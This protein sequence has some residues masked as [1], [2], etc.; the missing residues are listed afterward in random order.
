M[1]FLHF[2][3]YQP[4]SIIRIYAV[5]FVSV[6]PL[7]SDRCLTSHFPTFFQRSLFV[8]L[9]LVYP[10]KF[11][12]SCF[13]DFVCRQLN[14]CDVIYVDLI[15]FIL[16]FRK[17]T[18][19]VFFRAIRLLIGNCTDIEVSKIFDLTVDFHLF[20]NSF[21]NC[22]YQSGWIYLRCFCTAVDE[23]YV[24]MPSST[25]CSLIGTVALQD[26]CELPRIGCPLR[27]L[28]YI[29]NPTRVLALHPPST[30]GSF[31][32]VDVLLACESNHFRFSPWRRM[33]WMFMKEV[34]PF[35]S[36]IVVILDRYLQLVSSFFQSLL[37]HFFRDF[38]LVQTL[39]QWER[40]T[41]WWSC[42]QVRIFIIQDRFQILLVC[43][44]R[45]IPS[46]TVASACFQVNC[47]TWF[48]SKTV[49][50][51]RETWRWKYLRNIVLSQCMNVQAFTK[52]AKHFCIDGFFLCID[53]SYKMYIDLFDCCILWN[54]WC[55]LL[56]I[57]RF[58]RIISNISNLFIRQFRTKMCPR[59]SQTC[60]SG[61]SSR[62]SWCFRF[63]QLMIQI[64]QIF[65]KSLST[66]CLCLRFLLRSRRYNFIRISS[67][68][69]WFS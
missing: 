34:S 61:R 68:S 65:S 51:L 66:L 58:H 9:L 15:F 55:H 56:L 46:F 60:T 49:G 54:L 63:F 31:D 64:V 13:Q 30:H 23:L 62:N 41:G 33:G 22:C 2:P 18:F 3:N 69:Q 24:S 20:S 27:R 43:L 8:D 36:S 25:V 7:Q 57:W 4:W 44:V 10:T 53:K 47:I 50:S 21:Q 59:H 28:S 1:L 19:K 32:H 26:F 29:S 45:K 17:P 6:D 48:Q 11:F 39:Q 42:Q 52:L 67:F 40:F 35:L 12:V 37:S 5:S 38:I 14:S 16:L